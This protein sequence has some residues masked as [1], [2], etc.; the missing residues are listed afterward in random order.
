MKTKKLSTV[1]VKKCI[2]EVNEAIEKSKKVVKPKPEWYTFG[3]PSKYRP[4]FIQKMYE[5]FFGKSFY[6]DKI[7]SVWKFWDKTKERPVDF[8]TMEW[9]AATIWVLDKTMADRA[10]SHVDFSDMYDR[11]KA[12]QKEILIVNT[13]NWLYQSNFSIFLA[14]NLFKELKDR[15]TVEIDDVKDSLED[16]SEN[17]LKKK[18]E[19]IRKKKK[20]LK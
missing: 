20:P 4:E 9:F 8:P 5:Y 7:E 11:C 16:L 12:R 14:T 13:M 1:V 6:T 3:R 19:E 15:K 10:K 2:A 17:E 18:L